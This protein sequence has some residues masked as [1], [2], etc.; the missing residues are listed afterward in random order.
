MKEKVKQTVV[1]VLTFTMG[2]FDDATAGGVAVDNASLNHG[3]IF[4][5]SA[6]KWP[7]VNILLAFKLVCGGDNLF[8]Q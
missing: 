8:V 1:G 3:D 6:N 7:Y 5:S 2:F 4:S